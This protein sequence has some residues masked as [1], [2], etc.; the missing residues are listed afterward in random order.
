M[1]ASYTVIPLSPCIYV[2]AL[3][4][5]LDM[6]TEQEYKQRKKHVFIIDTI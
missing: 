6:S 5:Q 2:Q 1:Y 4:L 3:Y